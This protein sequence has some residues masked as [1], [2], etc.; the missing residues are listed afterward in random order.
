MHNYTYTRLITLD[1][2]FKTVDN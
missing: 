2:P 1:L